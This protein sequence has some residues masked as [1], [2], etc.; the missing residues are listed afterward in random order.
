[1]ARSDE[2]PP[3]PATKLIL[4][5]EDNEL[6]LKLL[7]DIL[8]FHGY[9]IVA[10]GLGGAALDL[11]RQHQPDL[12]LLDMQLPDISGL[13]V[14]QQ[15]KG[16][17]QT[18]MIPIIGVTAFAMPGDKRKVLESGCDFYVAKPLNIVELLE[19]VNGIIGGNPS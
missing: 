16:D 5:V 19:L 12:I 14:A 3:Q 6:N 18:R 13:D 11:A 8:E 7:N 2:D 4:I 9:E 10:T 17:E 15:F 1:L